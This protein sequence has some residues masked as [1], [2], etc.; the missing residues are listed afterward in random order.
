[1]AEDKIP[2]VILGAGGYATV[3]HEILNARLDVRLI[4][5]TDKALGISERSV[6]EGITLRIL[7]DDDILPQL[8]DQ[9]PG[10]HAVFALG[11]D[12]MDVR[13]RLIRRLDLEKI[14]SMTAIHRSA[15]ISPLAKVGEGTVVRGGAIIS[16]GSQIGR[17]SLIN[18]GASIDHDAHLGANV[19]VGQGAQ[20]SSYVQ[21]GDHVVIE[22]GASINSRVTIGAGARVTGG[23]FVNTDV[24]DH[25]VVVGVP[26]RV[27]R[28][29]SPL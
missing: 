18:L 19:Y 21:I 2:V 28:Y 24:P 17:Y 7:G 9:H 10:L 15:V 5:C 6:G 3:V 26:A 29:L 14:P 27:V 16:A 12:L 11:P 22:M 23:A 13:M 1:M 4:G 8:A 25:A 20:I